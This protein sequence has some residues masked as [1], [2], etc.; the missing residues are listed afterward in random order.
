MFRPVQSRLGSLLILAVSMLSSGLLVARASPE[1]A[2][3]AY[4]L[5]FLL[6]H[7]AAGALVDQ[8]GHARA[9]AD[10]AGKLVVVG[11]VTTR[12]SSLC[13]MRSLAM[14]EV[15]RDLPVDVRDRLR[16]VAIS[17]DPADKPA[18]LAAFADGLHLDTARWTL[19][20][21]DAGQAERIR[22]AIGQRILRPGES[23]AEPATN[24]FLFGGRGQLMQSFGGRALDKARF[25]RD[26]VALAHFEAET[27]SSQ[28]K[29]P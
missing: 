17:I 22:V 25:A 19:L 14:A 13:V 4:D 26:L 8:G 5:P 21:T 11:L 12:C 28:T 16:F 1:P 7:V 29:T 24:L 23:E 15:A 10:F 6:D 3:S 27:A 18:D 2:V 20:A 9:G